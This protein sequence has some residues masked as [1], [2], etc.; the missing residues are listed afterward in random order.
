VGWVG[1]ANRDEPGFRQHLLGRGIAAGGGRPQCAQPVPRRRQ[2]A[3]VPDGRGRHAAAGN[4]LRDPVAEFRSVV[5]DVEQI[6]PAEYRAVLG[7]EH[8][9]AQMPA[10]CSA[11]KALYRPVNWSKK[12]SPRSETDAAK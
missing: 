11:S 6:E 12:S 2:P 10:S 8:V 1:R 4:M 5:L 7:D 3:Q 9:E